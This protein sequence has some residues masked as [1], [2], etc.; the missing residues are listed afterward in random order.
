ME[1]NIF[2][3]E[4]MNK[5]QCMENTLL[6]VATGTYDINEI[7]RAVHTIKG[8][9]DLL[10]MVDVVNITHK[11]ENILDDI[12]NGKVVLDLKLSLQLLELKRFIALMVENL[13]SGNEDDEIVKNLSEYFE[14]ELFS[15][16][17]EIDKKTILII[18]DSLVLRERSKLVAQDMGYTAIT[19]TNGISGLEKIK[20][21]KID[22][23]FCD[24]STIEIGG[25]DMICQIKSNINYNH[26]PVVILV[27][28]K[29]QNM[30]DMAK[31]I[32]AK[33]WLL[34][35]FDKNKFQVILEKILG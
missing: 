1:D 12:R 13:L 2:Y 16:E 20:D 29:D 6:D 4:F 14:K 35:S 26:I 19:A 27:S 24:I 15:C 5:L 9:A 8:T 31:S 3:D 21:N 28:T 34:R 23:I 30:I 25:L 17:K 7:F 10:G 33:A 32:E 22:L 11:A 18:D